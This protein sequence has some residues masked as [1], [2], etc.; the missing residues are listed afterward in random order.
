MQLPKWNKFQ[1][2]NNPITDLSEHFPYGTPEALDLLSKM[3]NLDPKKRITAKEALQ[4][5]FFADCY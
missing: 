5:P 1:F 3:L 4:H 2:K